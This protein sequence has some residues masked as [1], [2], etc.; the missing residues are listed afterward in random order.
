MEEVSIQ[1]LRGQRLLARVERMKSL[2]LDPDKILSLDQRVYLRD[3]LIRKERATKSFMEQM[4]ALE[5]K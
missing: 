5:N 2:G 1:E 3:T 4:K